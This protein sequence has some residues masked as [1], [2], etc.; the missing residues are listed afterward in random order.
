MAAIRQVLAPTSRQTKPRAGCS[1]ARAAHAGVPLLLLTGI[2]LASGGALLCLATPAQ[3]SVSDVKPVAGDGVITEDF[4]EGSGDLFQTTH[5]VITTSISPTRIDPGDSLTGSVVDD[6]THYFYEEGCSPTVLP[7]FYSDLLIWE[8]SKIPPGVFTNTGDHLLLVSGTDEVNND[9]GCT[10]AN[11]ARRRF[12]SRSTFTVPGTSTQDLEPGCY[13]LY[14]PLDPGHEGGTVAIFAVG[15]T[16]A[17]CALPAGEFSLFVINGSENGGSG[18]VTGPGIN[19][20]LAGF[21][22]ECRESYPAG[23]TVTLTAIPQPGMGFAGWQ[24]GGCTGLALFCSVLMDRNR[25]VTAHFSSD[26]L[27]ED[28]IQEK[29]KAGWDESTDFFLDVG[30]ALADQ[31]PGFVVRNPE[32]DAVSLQIQYIA[33]EGGLVSKWLGDDPPDSHYTAIAQPQFPKAPKVKR[34]RKIS[35]KARKLLIKIGKNGARVH[36]FG[37][38]LLHCIERAQGAAIAGDQVWRKRQRACAAQNADQLAKT[39]G[40]QLKLRSSARKALSSLRKVKITKSAINKFRARLKQGKLPAFV[41][42]LGLSPADRKALITSLLSAKM[43]PTKLLSL[44]YSGKIRKELKAAQATATGTAKQ[45]SA[46]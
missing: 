39:F 22:P 27:R 9:Y 18:R 29:W 44:V 34:S 26:P 40:Q 11:H 16:A 46:P 20:G 5:R 7:P 30:S 6:L 24:S 13:A 33:F 41:D 32:R 17:L 25:V 2:L 37:T 21:G 28:T 3:A 31:G 45:Y 19:C 1:R 23:T 12:V 4:T 43:K 38:A 8:F 36:G 10:D 14:V 35:G 42:R 15:T